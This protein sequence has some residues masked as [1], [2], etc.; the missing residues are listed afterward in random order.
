MLKNKTNIWGENICNIFNKALVSMNQWEKDNNP[1]LKCAN[2]ISPGGSVVKNTLEME[3]MHVQ[4]LGQ[5]DPLEKEMVAYTCILV[6]RIPQT[7][8]P[9]WL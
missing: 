8:E 4:S 3:G 6:W 2:S 9:G 7:E 5:E 1:N